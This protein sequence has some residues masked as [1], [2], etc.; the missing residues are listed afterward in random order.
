MIQ[1][2]PCRQR[3]STIGPTNKENVPLKPRIMPIEFYEA[4]IQKIAHVIQSLATSMTGK[5][6][7]EAL[8]EAMEAIEQGTYSL[9]GVSQIFHIL[10]SFLFYHLNG[11]TRS[12]KM[13]SLEMLTKKE[14][15]VLYEWILAMGEV[16][17]QYH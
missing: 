6:T 7:S 2:V 4:P 12:R 10:L 9:W 5:W 16:A 8:K 17:C 13:G 1:I 11:C 3:S 14:D 15:A